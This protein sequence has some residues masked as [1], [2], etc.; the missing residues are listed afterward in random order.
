MNASAIIDARLR[1]VPFNNILRALESGSDK[2]SSLTE[3]QSVFFE[4][5]LAH[6]KKAVA[7]FASALECGDLTEIKRVGECISELFA[8]IKDGADDSQ[9]TD[10]R[11]D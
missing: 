4:D 8:M 9:G 5:M 7:E 10:K 2:L 1:D 6:A 3:E 11:G